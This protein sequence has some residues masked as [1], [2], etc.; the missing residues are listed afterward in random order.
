MGSRSG[1][2]NALV[3]SEGFE[4]EV[5]SLR[6]GK[7][8]FESSDPAFERTAMALTARGQ[9][10][11]VGKVPA[12]AAE[13]S[14]ICLPESATDCRLSDVGF[15][16]AFAAECALRL[17]QQSCDCIEAQASPVTTMARESAGDAISREGAA[18]AIFSQP[19][20]Q[21]AP[22]IQKATASASDTRPILTEERNLIMPISLNL[23]AR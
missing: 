15:A 7:A 2:A 21:P 22:A 10:I 4:S 23:R 19:S 11:I 3:C 9:S 18:L 17:A 8:T 5:N 20:M 6:D 14:G 16:T 13:S 12:S 1:R